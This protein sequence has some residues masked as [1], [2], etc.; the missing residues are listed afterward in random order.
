M[1]F[2]NLSDYHIFRDKQIE[3][4]EKIVY[5]E[6]LL[7]E[8]F[9][10]YY[11]KKK[12]Y[13]EKEKE[14]NEKFGKYEKIKLL[15]YDEELEYYRERVNNYAKKLENE[16]KI[17]NIDY[18]LIAMLL[19]RYKYSY[20]YSKINISNVVNGFLTSYEDYLNQKESKFDEE[21]F[22]KID[23]DDGTIIEKNFY[24]NN[25]KKDGIIVYKNFYTNKNKKYVFKFKNAVI[26][27]Y[28]YQNQSDNKDYEFGNYE[29]IKYY[30]RIFDNEYL[31]DLIEITEE[32]N[33]N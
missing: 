27:E 4:D 12:E 20:I 17:D 13:V 18:R 10:I 1:I 29:D 19:G 2:N 31:A 22:K 5:S 3:N 7:K 6:E 26:Y 24:D 23:F 11:N 30:L 14:F 32:D 28:N 8:Q 9:N 25:G 33:E 21:I 15:S 16:L